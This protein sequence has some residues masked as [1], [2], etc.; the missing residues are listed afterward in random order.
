MKPT[1]TVLTF[2]LI[3]TI[4]PAP[5]SAA[6]PAVEFYCTNN[7][8]E[9]AYELCV[10]QFKPTAAELAYARKELQKD[11]PNKETYENCVKQTGGY[12]KCV[13]NTQGLLGVSTA[14]ARYLCNQRNAELLCNLELREIGITKAGAKRACA[15]QKH[16]VA[17]PNEYGWDCDQTSDSGRLVRLKGGWRDKRAVVCE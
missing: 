7:F 3:I 10:A 4:R 6:D 5:A 2:L 16:G 9:A 14:R 12:D 13:V 15:A 1:L 17:G 11:V 8:A